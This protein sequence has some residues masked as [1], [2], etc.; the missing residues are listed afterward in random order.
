MTASPAATRT[1]QASAAPIPGD[2]KP[3][4]GVPALVDGEAAECV[5]RCGVGH[6]AGGAL[7]N[8]RYQTRWFFG[9]YMTVTTDGTWNLGEDSNAELSLPIAE[10]Y[11]IAFSLDP[12][13]VLHGSVADDVALEADSYIEW[14]SGHPDLTVSEPV[15]T[16]IGSVPATAV[17]I[18][19]APGAGQDEADCGTDPCITFIKNPAIPAQF[20]HVD[21]ILGDD[22]Y[23]F[24]FADVAYSG[25][26]HLLVVKVEGDDQAQLEAPRI[27]ELL[28]SVSVPARPR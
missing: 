21:G 13:L 10:G 24:Y 22:V 20:A 12:Q 1:A 19:L 23:R 26:D 18:S 3:R 17:D 8:G 11:Q 15:A 25:S 9:G 27:H 28:Q 5:P 14:L 2:L 7:P 16:A 6:I 4:Q